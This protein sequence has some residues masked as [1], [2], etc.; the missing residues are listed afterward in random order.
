MRSSVTAR[1]CSSESFI[2]GA[3]SGSTPTTSTLRPSVWSHRQ[4][5]TGEQSAAA[6]R[7]DEHLDLRPVLGDLQTD[8]AGA[9]SVRAAS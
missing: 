2:V 1:P 3:P 8:R 7:H 9:L 4:R 5:G 6:D